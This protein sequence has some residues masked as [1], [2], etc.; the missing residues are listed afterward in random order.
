MDDPGVGRDDPEVA[1]R[2]LAPA[3]EGVALAVPAEL[4]VGV[5]Q[6]G[7]R[8]PGL[9]DLDRV[10]D[11]QLDRLER[12]DLRRVAAQPLHGVAHGGQ[13]DDGRDAGEVLEQDPARP[14]GDLAD[15]DRLGVPVGQAQDVVGGDRRAVLV[16]EQVLQQDL[17]RERQPRQV[18][19]RVSEAVEPEDAEG[20]VVH[21]QR[22][23]GVEAVRHGSS[24][25]QGVGR[26]GERGYGS[27][28]GAEVRTVPRTQ[29]A[30]RSGG[31][32]VIRRIVRQRARGLNPLPRPARAGCG[33]PRGPGARNRRS[34]R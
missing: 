16:A 18:D 21:L 28:A 8:G 32:P 7:A 13:V 9:V 1:E 23:E 30:F 10:V 19:P 31:S 34:I 4:Q 17:Q 3:E 20:P 5:G 24:S 11:D 15:R 6:E 12:V 2:V 27:H 33:P 26:E 22:R 29:S 25:R 14:E